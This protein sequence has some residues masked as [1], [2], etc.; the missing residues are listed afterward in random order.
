MI[1]SAITLKR[2]ND[3]SFITVIIIAFLEIKSSDSMMLFINITISV[4]F[5]YIKTSYL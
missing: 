4:F 2:T 1:F 3:C 5:I